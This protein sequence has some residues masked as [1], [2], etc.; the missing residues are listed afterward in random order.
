MTSMSDPKLNP[1]GHSDWPGISMDQFRAK[2]T[3]FLE[4]QGY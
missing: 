2:L 3:T 4:T 1:D